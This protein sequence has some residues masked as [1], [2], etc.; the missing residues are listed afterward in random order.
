MLVGERTRLAGD[1]QRLT[2]PKQ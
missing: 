2:S 1:S